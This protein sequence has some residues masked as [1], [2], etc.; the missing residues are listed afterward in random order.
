MSGRDLL[1]I[2]V[3]FE[4]TR[5]GLSFI[6]DT[7]SCFAISFFPVSSG[8]ETLQPNVSPYRQWSNSVAFFVKKLGLGNLL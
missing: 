1:D 3:D 7:P 8:I 5:F 4:G 2:L 6:L